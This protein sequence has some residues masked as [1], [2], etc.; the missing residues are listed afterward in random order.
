MQLVKERG[1]LIAALPKAGVY[2]M[3]PETCGGLEFD[4]V[5]LVGID[6]GRVPP[7]MGDL[8]PQGYLSV[9]EE[10]FK[11]LYTAVTRAR[12]ALVFACDSRRGLSSLIKP[13]LMSHLVDEASLLGAKK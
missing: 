1:E 12:Y 3:T 8:S 5:L 6:E 9:Q 13:S 10:A 11:E 7:P 4:A 2:L